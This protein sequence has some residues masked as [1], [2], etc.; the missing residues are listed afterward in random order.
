MSTTSSTNMFQ[1]VLKDAQGVQ[2]KLLGP[3]YPYYNNIK[4]PSQLGMSSNGSLSALGSDINGLINYV[5]VLVEGKSKASSTGQPLGNKFFLKTGAKCLATDTNQQVDRYIYIDNVPDGSIPFISQGLGVNFS[6]F[7]GLIPG[8]MG[9][10]NVLNPFTIM[11]S[12]LSGSTPPCQKLT[13]QTIDVNN[14][15]SSETNY[16]TLIDIQNMNPCTFQNGTNPVSGK[17]CRQAFGTFTQSQYQEIN[18]DQIK[19]PQDPLAQLYFL[20]LSAVAVYILYRL[21]EKEK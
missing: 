16:V 5:T 19:L 2:N 15:S 4:T 7:R 11:Q 20:S 18:E 10:L 6:D 1:E 14:N 17:S 21:M 13:M 8:A 3:T 12:F 9:D